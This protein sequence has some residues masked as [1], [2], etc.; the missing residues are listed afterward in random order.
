M[1]EVIIVHSAEELREIVR[2]VENGTILKIR[3]EPGEEDH[4]DDG[5]AGAAVPV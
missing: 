2:N 4:E 5:R 3:I 1:K